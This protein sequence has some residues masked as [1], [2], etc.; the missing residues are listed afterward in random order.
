MIQVPVIFNVSLTFKMGVYLTKIISVVYYE[1][2]W[3]FK[4]TALHDKQN[5]IVFLNDLLYLCI[6]SL[7][8]FMSQ[9]YLNARHQ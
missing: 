8:I 3:N 4:F 9:I 6:K 7:K 1:L 2:K 5:F